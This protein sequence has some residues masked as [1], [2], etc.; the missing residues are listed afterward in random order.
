MTQPFRAVIFD[1]DGVIAEQGFRCA[2]VAATGSSEVDMPDL[3]REGMI[4]LLKSGYVTGTGSE[5]AFARIFS[6]R[7]GRH[8][9]VDRLRDVIVN[10]SV[11]RPWM[12]ALSEGLQGAGFTTAV[13]TDHT[14]WLDDIERRSPF[15]HAFGHVFNSYS[16]GECKAQADVF[17]T[18]VGRLGVP[19][20]A[21]IFI[22][23]N[24]ANVA[25]ARSK[26]LAGIVYTERAQL[27]AELGAILGPAFDSVARSLPESG[28]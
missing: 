1:F 21:A 24:P 13:L 7:T 19:G 12:L 6:Q 5:A 9:D 11:V 15:Q 14:D 3:R 20:Q 18:V 27:L 23:D 10:R 4:A 17:A 25:R 22:D 2:L 16:L 26:G 28:S 8:L